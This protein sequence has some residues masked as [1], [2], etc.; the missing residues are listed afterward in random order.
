M[1]STEIHFHLLP[2]VDDGPRSMDET[3]ELARLAAADGTRAITVTPHVNHSVRLDV[4]SL[5]ARVAEVNDRLRRERI[6]IEAVCGG[7]LAPE[8][9]GTLTQEELELIA[10]GPRGARWL[11]L[12]A[13][14]DG[15]GALF[16]DAADDLRERGFGMVVAHPERSLGFGREGWQILER[17][18]QLG[19]ALQLNAWSLAGLN[20][21]RARND[22]IKLLNAGPRI[23]IASDAHGTHRPPSL[24]LALES[25]A[26][27]GEREPW[28]FIDAVPNGLL[29][30][31]LPVGSRQLAA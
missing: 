30:R 23:A 22:A 16:R 6:P 21:E 7:E 13:P 24:K 26:A 1:S 29:E 15:I 11:L 27:L 31:G 28:R 20:G 18:L 14:L 2:G 19:S 25:V 10:H 3:V 17:E 12:E 8:R 4:M 9:A 5:P